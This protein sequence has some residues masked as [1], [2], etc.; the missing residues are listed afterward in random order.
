MEF[1]LQPTNQ[2]S[3]FV[4]SAYLI[5]LQ[6]YIKTKKVCNLQIV[7]KERLLNCSGTVLIIFALNKLLHIFITIVTTVCFS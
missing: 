6:F 1:N 5:S 4:P 2:I 3:H 7:L